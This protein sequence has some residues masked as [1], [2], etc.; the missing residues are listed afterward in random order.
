[1]KNEGD[2]KKVVKEFLTGRGAWWYMPVPTGFG[3]Q[4]VPDFVG[5]YDGSAFFVETKFGNRKTT[6]W[7]DRQI[8]AIRGRGGKVWIVNEKNLDSFK[9]Q[10]L[11]WE[12]MLEAAHQ[13]GG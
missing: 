9:E 7:Q 11:A 5:V 3:V 4:G 13:L 6:A 12:S 1:M 10:F 8:A 2:V